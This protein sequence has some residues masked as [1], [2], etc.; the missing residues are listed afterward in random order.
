MCCYHH[1]DASSTA[2]QS[3]VRGRGVFLVWAICAAS[4]ASQRRL[5][6]DR[7]AWSSRKAESSVVSL[8]VPGPG[9]GIKYCVVYGLGRWTNRYSQ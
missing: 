1:Q 5:L 6:V 4:Q 9:P 8:L 7:G 2:E 3:S